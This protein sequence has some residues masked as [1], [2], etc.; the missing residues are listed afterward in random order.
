MK[1][2]LKDDYN[3]NKEEFNKCIYNYVKPTYNE[4]AYNHTVNKFFTENMKKSF[5]N[6]RYENQL[7]LKLSK[8]TKF[9]KYNNLK[10]NINEFHNEYIN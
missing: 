1:N 2:S 6:I 3:E 9:L 7:L 10:M 8:N 5:C 4:S